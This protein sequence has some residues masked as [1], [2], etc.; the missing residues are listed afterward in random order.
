M[1]ASDGGSLGPLTIALTKLADG[2]HPSLELIG[3]G[4][5]LAAD[6]DA[7]RVQRVIAGGGAA[8]AGIVVGDR[9]VAVDGVSV[10]PLGVERR[11]LRA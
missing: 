3:I 5:Q 11:K 6:G 1:T 9:L 10:T 7:L 8:A 4:V 2:E